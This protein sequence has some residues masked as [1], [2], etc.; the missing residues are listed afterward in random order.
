MTGPEH[1]AEGERLLAIAAEANDWEPLAARAQAHFTAALAAATALAHFRPE[2]QPEADRMAWYRA[3]SEGPGE[4]PCVA[5]AKLNV[6]RNQI[7]AGLR[8]EDIEI[9][10]VRPGARPCGSGGQTTGEFDPY[11]RITHKA[12]GITVSCDTERSQLMNKD[13]ALRELARQLAVRQIRASS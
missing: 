8:D 13:A 12:T 2:G 7:L 6:I 1:Y 9:S 5:V 11:V 4:A 10:T 3:A